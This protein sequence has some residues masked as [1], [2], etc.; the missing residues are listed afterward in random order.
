MRTI[1]LVAVLSFLGLSA[2]GGV[3]GEKQFEG[4]VASR[5]HADWIPP[6]SLRLVQLVNIGTRAQVENLIILPSENLTAYQNLKAA[7]IPENEIHDGSLGAG[8][9]YCCGGTIS[10]ETLVIFYIP[11]GLDVNLGDIVEVKVGEPPSKGNLGTFPNFVTRV[12]QKADE[13]DGCRWIPENPDLWAR[14]LYCQGLEKDGWIQSKSKVALEAL[15]YRPP[16]P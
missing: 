13:N 7:G 8:I 2:C 11:E 4:Q 3:P 12:R 6:H 16:Q 5:L 14:V 1:K 10:H 9:A 15:W